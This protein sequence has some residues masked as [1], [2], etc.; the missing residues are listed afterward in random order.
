ML[1]SLKPRLKMVLIGIKVIDKIA[2][3][4]KCTS[5]YGENLVLDTD[6]TIIRASVKQ[7]NGPRLIN[8]RAGLL[9]N[10]VEYL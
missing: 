8:I 1:S 3:T 10:R 7:N 9:S 4:F 5:E 2:G 6:A